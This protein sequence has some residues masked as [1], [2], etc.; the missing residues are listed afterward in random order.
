MRRFR[1]AFANPRWHC[2]LFYAA[3]ALALQ[4]IAK[5]AH[6]EG[7]GFDACSEG[8]L[9]TA[10]Q[11]GVP[12]SECILHGCA[13]TER[14]LELALRSRI[15][16][17][18]IDN[19]EELVALCRL[20]ELANVRVPILIRVN[21]GL[22]APTIAQIQTSS[23]ESKFG[24]PIEDGQARAA[25]IEIRRSPSLEL[26]GLHCH[27]G[28]QI[29]DLSVYAEVVYRLS[30]L[31]LAFEREDVS[32]MVLNVGG[33]LGVPEHDTDPNG[34]TPEAWAKTLFVALDKWFAGNENRR[35]L[36]IEPGRAIV[37]PAGM[38]LY[39]VGVRKKMA[40]GDQA[41]IVDGGMSDNP[42]PALYE[43]A[44]DVRVA[45]RP[46][47]APDG[48]YWI[49]GRHCEADLLFRA[50]PLPN[51]QAGDVLLVRNTGAYTYSM[52]SNYNRF[53]KPAVVLTNGDSARIIAKRE[54]LEHVLDLDL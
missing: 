46:E 27:I 38:T 5:I 6:E 12:P 15:R 2:S 40:N 19:R 48:K 8:E 29:T 4:A 41:V 43:A 54:P 7:L 1:K 52:A 44:Y 53:P 18:V 36:M 34:S 35:R 22:S 33:G 25:A 50:V 28:S 16:F 21:V 23:P 26:C 39:S 9:Q 24:F 31:A 3:K 32:C 45:S 17:I 49:F 13:K 11:A 42:R 37:A 14:E 10:L 51:P 30:V 47:A 20:A